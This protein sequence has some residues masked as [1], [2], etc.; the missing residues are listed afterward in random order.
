MKC[1]VDGYLTLFR[2]VACRFGIELEFDGGQSPVHF[3]TEIDLINCGVRGSLDR[4]LL[5][6]AD[7]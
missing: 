4:A 3:H 2:A 7:M 5:R 6:D 1:I